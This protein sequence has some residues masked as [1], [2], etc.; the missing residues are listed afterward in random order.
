MYLESN[1]I[2]SILLQTDR[3]HSERVPGVSEES[4]VLGVAGKH[5][6]AWGVKGTRISLMWPSATAEDTREERKDT[7]PQALQSCFVHCLYNGNG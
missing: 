5:E 3:F 2:K 6:G 7:S 4:E 1:Y